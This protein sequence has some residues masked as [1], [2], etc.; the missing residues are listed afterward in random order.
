[1]VSA[2]P[3]LRSTS[4]PSPVGTRVGDSAP[5]SSAMPWRAPVEFV[6]ERDQSLACRAG[7]RVPQSGRA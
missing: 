1:L 7:R 4:A 6:D 5:M 2:S 3:T